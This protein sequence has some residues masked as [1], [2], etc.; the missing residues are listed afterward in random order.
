MRGTRNPKWVNPMKERRI[1]AQGA[2]N[3][4]PSIASTEE[5]VKKE[6]GESEEKSTT[7]ASE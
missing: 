5:E 2:K 6:C 7:K 1:W 3:W 4:E